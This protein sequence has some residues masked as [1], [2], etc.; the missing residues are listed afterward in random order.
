MDLKDCPICLMLINE[1]SVKERPVALLSCA[2]LFHYVCLKM[3]EDCELVSIRHCPVCR[4]VYT[5]KVLKTL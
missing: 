5:K 1:D 3:Y 2:H 4:H